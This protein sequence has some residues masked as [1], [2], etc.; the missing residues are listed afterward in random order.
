M[1]ILGSEKPG[2]DTIIASGYRSSMPHGVATNKKIRKGEFV[3]L[4][5]GAIYDG[6]HS[7]ITRTIVVGKATP[8]QK[9]I[10]HLVLTAQQAGCRYARA[11]LTGKE[12]D[13]K[14]RRI[15]EKA[16]YGKYFG[17]GLGHGI[18]TVVHDAPAIS[19]LS[20]TVLKPNMVVTIEPGVYLPGWGGVRIEDDVVIKRN[21]CE[22]LNRAEKNLIEL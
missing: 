15:I 2:F 13:G 4:D 5:F 22:I 12:V 1:K 19:T 6:Y 17:H 14:V 21:S 7:D 20:E 9:K 11:G 16:G 18:G 3:T 8:R 10:Y